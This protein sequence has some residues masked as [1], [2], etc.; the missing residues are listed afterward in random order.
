MSSPRPWGCFQCRHAFTSGAVVFPTPVGVF[1]LLMS[2]EVEQVS[3][4]HARGGVSCLLKISDSALSSSPR[5]WGCFSNHILSK[6]TVDVFPTPV[7]VFLP[8]KAMIV[9]VGSLPHARGGVSIFIALLPS[10][11][12][13]SPRPWGC[14][15]SC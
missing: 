6:V 12:S 11:V 3:L 2:V 8:A 9:P 13:S 4:P 1:P 5:P 15:S 10:I 7:G 14:F